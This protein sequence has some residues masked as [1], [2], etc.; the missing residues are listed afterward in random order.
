MLRAEIL[1]KELM[2]VY[3]TRKVHTRTETKGGPSC[4]LSRDI[5]H[6]NQVTL[7]KDMFLNP[8]H[9]SLNKR[10]TLHLSLCQAVDLWVTNPNRASHLLPLPTLNQ[11]AIPNQAAIPNQEATPNPVVTLLNQPTL[12]SQ[13]TLN[14]AVTLLNQPTLNQAAL[15]VIVLSAAGTVASYSM[16]KAERHVLELM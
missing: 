1:H 7:L 4:L 16:L 5:P 12:L 11:V 6:P 10:A 14:Q 9:I 3:G 8:R 15:E 13:P 2:L